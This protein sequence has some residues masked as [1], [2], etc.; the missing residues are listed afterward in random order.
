MARWI[1][2]LA[3]VVTIHNAYTATPRHKVIDIGVNNI[4]GVIGRGGGAH[5]GLITILHER[6]DVSH[7]APPP[8]CH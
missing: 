8:Q 6:A 2:P 7:A 3:G 4:I 1:R 5:N